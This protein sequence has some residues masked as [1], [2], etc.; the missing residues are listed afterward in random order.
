[1]K[2]KNITVELLFKSRKK[3]YIYSSIENSEAVLVFERD[4]AGFNKLSGFV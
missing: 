2:I 4:N 1:M 3:T